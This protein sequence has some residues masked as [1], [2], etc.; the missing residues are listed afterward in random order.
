VLERH[1][2]VLGRK[3]AELNVGCNERACNCKLCISL[4]SDSLGKIRLFNIVF[5]VVFIATVG[6]SQPRIQSIYWLSKQWYLPSGPKK[7]HTV[8]IAITCVYCQSI[9]IIFGTYIIHYR[10]FATGWCIVSPPNMVCVTT[11]PCKI[12]LQFYPCSLFQKCYPF[13]LVI[14]ANFF[15]NFHKHN[16]WKNRTWRLLV[17]ISNGYSCLWPEPIAMAADDALIQAMRESC[18][19]LRQQRLFIIVDHI[20]VMCCNLR[21]FIY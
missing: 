7:L 11:L 4:P 13:T 1:L 5:V 8:F 15:S 16:F 20:P 2:H 17:I 9:F 3:R 12:L 14:I 18:G 21:Y 6:S 10:K 19:R